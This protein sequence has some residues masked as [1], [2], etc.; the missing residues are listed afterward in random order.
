MACAVR[1][2]FTLA[3][4]IREGS[5]SHGA[6]KFAQSNKSAMMSLCLQ[7]VHDPSGV[8]ERPRPAGAAGR[9]FGKPHGKHRLCAPGMRPGPRDNR[10][11][12]RRILRGHSPGTWLAPSA[13]C[14]GWRGAPGFSGTG[15]QRVASSHRVSRLAEKVGQSHVADIIRL[16]HTP[17]LRPKFLYDE[18]EPRRDTIKI[19]D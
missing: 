1:N 16:F 9:S 18:C 6:S 10:A 3:A 17:R 15:C 8:V 12:G 7:I 13:R 2:G 4:L 19:S 14:L 5:Q 11:Y